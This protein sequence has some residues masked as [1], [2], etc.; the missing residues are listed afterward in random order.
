VEGREVIMFSFDIE[1]IPNEAMIDHLP[2]PEVKTGNLKD[3]EKIKAKAAEAKQKQIDDMALSPFYGRICSIATWGE[4]Q[5]YDVIDEISD[6]AEIELITKTLE[7]MSF[8][9]TQSP[10]VVTWNG[11]DFDFPFLYKRAALLKIA[12]PAG[13]PGLSYWTK[14]YST[15]PHCDLMAVLTGWSGRLKLDEAAANF[16]GEKKLGHDFSKFIELIKGGKGHEIGIYNLK[17][18]ELTFNLFTELSPYLF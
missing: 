14:R 7:K 3:I 17:D 12:M 15:V 6:A 11:L 8:G 2:E 4:Y 1:T 5:G 13:C 9:A 10:S 18:A 16:L